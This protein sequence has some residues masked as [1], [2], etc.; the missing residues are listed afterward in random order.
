M[1]MNDGRLG[2]LGA[3]V[4]ACEL[5]SGQLVKPKGTDRYFLLAGDQDGRIT[6]IK[7]LQTVKRLPGGKFELTKSEADRAA[8]A[9]EEYERRKAQSKPLVIVRGKPALAVA[10]G[11]EKAVDG[12][13]SFR[14]A[15]AYDAANLYV[16]YEVKSPHPLT[17]AVADPKLVFKG[18]NLLDVQL[19]CNPKAPADRKKPAPGDVRLLVSREDG[20]TKAVLFRPKVEGFRGEPT[21]LESPT[22]SESFDRVEPVGERVGLEYREDR[23]GGGFTAVVTVP[24]GLVG[25]ELQPGDEL[26]LDLG[27]IFGNATG[28]QAAVR[29][30]WTNNSFTANVTGDVPHESRLEPHEWG[31]ATVE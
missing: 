1:V 24:L 15:V 13:R 8:K 23:S 12:D 16:S 22:G 27:Y 6:E 11:V 28:T 17:S 31:T 14:A 19:A 9:L 20:R 29:A 3:D 4:L 30:Y 2:G 25:L 18:G 7:G 5:F 26:K 10:E 21:V